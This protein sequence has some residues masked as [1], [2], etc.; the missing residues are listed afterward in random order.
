MI[1]IGN[2]KGFKVIDP[3]GNELKELI[4]HNALKSFI[5]E[6]N[7][8]IVYKKSCEEGRQL[9]GVDNAKA[10]ECFKAAQKIKDNDYVNRM[11]DDC[12]KALTGMPETNRSKKFKNKKQ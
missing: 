12:Q 5:D 10:L 1:E 7:D 8:S 4:K 9:I 11:I 2:A 3:E 6:K